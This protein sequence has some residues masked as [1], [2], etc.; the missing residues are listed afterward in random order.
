MT[1]LAIANRAGSAGK[2]TSAVTLAALLAAAGTQVRLLDLDAQG[3]A[4]HWLG[5]THAAAPTIRDVLLGSDTID[6]VERVVAGLP[7]LTVVPADPATMEGVETE[8]GK[9][10][11]GEQAVRRALAQA[12][13]VEHTIID[14]PGS[15]GVLTIAALIAADIAITVFAPT[16]KEAG[17]VSRFETT[18]A[19]VAVAYDKPSLRLGAVLPCIVPAAGALYSQV[20]DSLRAGYGE[21][22]TPPIRRTVRIPESYSAQQP[23]N[24]FAPSERVV[25]DYRDVLAHLAATG[26]IE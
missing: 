26:V 4:S 7:T 18:V 16:E 5:H 2:T 12:G 23:P 19:E 6:D 1:I 15:L 8:L 17:G 24:V 22:V 25:Q 21:L 3:N 11:G 10:L 9:K 13:D 14:C 20:L